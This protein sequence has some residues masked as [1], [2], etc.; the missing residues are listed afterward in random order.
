MPIANWTTLHAGGAIYRMQRQPQ[1]HR[2]IA[3]VSPP[4]LR[5]RWLPC[6]ACQARRNAHVRSVTALTSGAVTCCCG[7]LREAREHSHSRVFALT[8]VHAGASTAVP[9]CVPRRRVA[10]YWCTLLPWPLQ[11]CFG[12][13]VKPHKQAAP[14]ELASMQRSRL[15]PRHGR[16]KCLEGRGR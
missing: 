8:E 3:D 5:D 2:C 14:G 6:I 7:P 13:I 1:E 9:F 4:A 15:A 12:R 10:E 11:Q 16:V